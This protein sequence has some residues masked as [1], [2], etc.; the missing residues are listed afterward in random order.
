HAAAEDLELARA[1]DQLDPD[2]GPRVLHELEDVRL[3]RR[4]PG[5]L[6]DDVE[7]LA[8][9][10]A[11][12]ALRVA[13]GEAH[14]VEESVGLLGVVA[15]VRHAW[16]LLGRGAPE[17]RVLTDDPHAEEEDLV[18]LVAVD[19]EGERLAESTVAEQG[20]H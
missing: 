15:G 1:D 4:L 20:P 16:V 7:P 3:L 11:P 13:G 18:D 2:L 19:G 12:V 9:R 10:T 5:R 14:L 17:D 8:V 6:D